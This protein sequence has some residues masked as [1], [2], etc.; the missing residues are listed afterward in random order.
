MKVNIEI[1]GKY[2]IH[3]FNVAMILADLNMD[4]STI[5]AGL[6]HDVIEDTEITYE[7]IKTEFGEEIADLVDGV[8]KLKKITI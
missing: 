4:E 5:V 8:T 1:Q 2:F 6:L 7:E 3:P